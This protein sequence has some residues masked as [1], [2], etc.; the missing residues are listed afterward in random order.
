MVYYKCI[1]CNFITDKKS[2]YQ[3]HLKTSKHQNKINK[4]SKYS[5]SNKDYDDKHIM[6]LLLKEKDE[7]IKDNQRYLDLI[8]KLQDKTNQPI[9]NHNETVYN[10]NINTQVNNTNYVLNYIN[11]QTADTMESV[12]EKFRLTKEEYIKASL[13]NGYRGALLD[14]A[15]NIII[16]PY[17]DKKNKRPIQTVDSSRRKAL[18]KDLYHDN[19]TFYPKTSLEHCF[20]EFHI[21][22]LEQQDKTIRDNPY[23]LLSNNEIDENLY[24]Q[25]YFVPTDDKEKL[26]IYRDVSNHIYK[27]TKVLR[28]NQ[29]NGIDDVI[30]YLES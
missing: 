12:K 23:L 30:K 11:F 16:K 6:K 26:T 13:T 8:E 2:N 14:K 27:K 19:W 4:N 17:L 20:K 7:R 15:E 24:R 5:K 28:D 29:I 3:R 10:Q 21:S 18:F 22:A 9:I 1:E 25:T